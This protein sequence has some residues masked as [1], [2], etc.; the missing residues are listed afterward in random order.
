MQEWDNRSH[1][2]PIPSREFQ[3]ISGATTLCDDSEAEAQVQSAIAANMTAGASAHI[4]HGAISSASNRHFQCQ[5]DV[6]VASKIARTI[7]AADD[8]VEE[9]NSRDSNPRYVSRQIL[10]GL[11][12]HREWWEDVVMCGIE[13]GLRD[14]PKTCSLCVEAAEGWKTKKCDTCGGKLK[15]SVMTA[16]ASFLHSKKKTLQD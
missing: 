7:V 8:H 15:P 5:Y 4:E 9:R 14:P 6:D 12:R 3:D 13:R 11:V 2:L 10:P 16:A 1:R